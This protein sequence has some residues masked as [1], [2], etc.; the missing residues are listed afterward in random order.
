MEKKRN[1]NWITKKKRK[2]KITS[3]ARHRQY[4][5]LGKFFT[6]F[7]VVKNS[8]FFRQP[9]VVHH[10]IDCCS[11]GKL[12]NRQWQQ[13]APAMTGN[14]TDCGSANITKRVTIANHCTE[15]KATKSVIKTAIA[16]KATKGI[17]R[18]NVHVSITLW[19]FCESFSFDWSEYWRQ[20][21]SSP[22]DRWKETENVQCSQLI[23][24]NTFLFE[25]NGFHCWQ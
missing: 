1:K 8:Q 3:K 4:F 12:N 6:S 21:C 19:A 13:T 18:K 25:R 20:P 10:S 16:T 5:A 23:K 7:F 15:L 2:P 14:S 17:H 9:F 22:Y 11:S 24:A